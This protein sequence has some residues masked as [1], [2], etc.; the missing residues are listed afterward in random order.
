M[1]LPGPQGYSSGHKPLQLMAMLSNQPDAPQGAG[2]P[3]TTLS[4]SMLFAVPHQIFLSFPQCEKNSKQ[5][6]CDA[7]KPPPPAS[8]N[9]HGDVLPAQCD[10]WR[11]IVPNV[12]ACHGNESRAGTTVSMDLHDQEISIF[13]VPPLNTFNWRKH[14]II[15]K[16]FSRTVL[17]H[18]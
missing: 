18:L 6:C 12:A 7:A 15:T 3:G 8:G 11:D 10:T 2:T 13:T 1:S 14:T 9:S 16:L 4:H 17:G 5:S